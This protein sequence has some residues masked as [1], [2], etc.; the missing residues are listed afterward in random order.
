MQLERPPAGMAA[1]AALDRRH[2]VQDRFDEQAVVSVGAGDQHVQRQPV[3]VDEQVVQAGSPC[4]GRSGC[5]RSAHPPYLWRDPRSTGSV[6]LGPIRRPGACAGPQP[7]SRW[8][9][10]GRTTLTAARTGPCCSPRRRAGW[11]VRS[12]A[13]PG[14]AWWPEGAGI[15]VG[16]AGARPYLGARS[17]RCSGGSGDMMID[18]VSRQGAA[19][20]SFEADRADAARRQGAGRSRP[21][22][23]VGG[24]MR[25]PGVRVRPGRGPPR[26]GR[27]GCGAPAG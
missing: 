8:S 23:S 24:L 10:R 5:G 9:A 3:S 12:S 26:R 17:F 22:A 15:G 4:P 19:A 13:A 2:A 1:A 16:C 14:P 25:A 11:W 20:R 18:G 21:R 27:A 7:R 6:V